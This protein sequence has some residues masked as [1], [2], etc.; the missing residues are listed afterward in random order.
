[1]RTPIVLLSCLLLV[2]AGASA[3]DGAAKRA[4]L[5]KKLSVSLARVAADLVELVDQ[6]DASKVDDAL[7]QIAP[8]QQALTD[9]ADVASGDAT[10]E[11]MVSSWPNYVLR[12]KHSLTALKGLKQ[13]QHGYD[14]VPAE[15]RHD[16]AELHERMRYWVGHADKDAGVKELTERATTLGKSWKKRFDADDSD[17]RG[18]AS[19]AGGMGAD[20]G[21]WAPVSRWLIRDANA[22][23]EIRSTGEWHQR[24]ACDRIMEGA[25]EPDVKLAI[26]E[27]HAARSR[28]DRAFADVKQD[29]ED[30]KT[31]KAEVLKEHVEHLEETR[32]F[33]CEEYET[34]IDVRVTGALQDILRLHGAEAV[35]L[36]RAD[37]MLAQLAKLE[38]DDATKTQ[39]KELEAKIERARGRV[40]AAAKQGLM[41]FDDP[42]I[43]AASWAGRNKHAEM[44]KKCGAT[45]V[46]IGGGNVRLDCVDLSGTAPHGTCTVV[47]IEPNNDKAA[48]AA[49]GQAYEYT[50]WL[51]HAHAKD[52]PDGSIFRKCLADDDT[53]KLA[54]V[55]VRTYDTCPKID[56]V[57]SFDTATVASDE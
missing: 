3:G 52:L 51:S 26:D 55:E 27:L 40:E 39:V 43:H 44:R 19:A 45:K 18:D 33:I 37:L 48:S 23:W 14:G 2:P 56:D 24:V 50:D 47:M 17:D 57:A 46:E 12:L 25:D 21:D 7:A 49:Q 53:L 15:C 35:L 10:A 20:E 16:E 38:H 30:W 11:E 42:K 36:G 29:Y 34:Q 4:E 9:L 54:A 6:P 32:T 13:R 5:T 41:A 1:M 28:P 8:M 31:A 22:L